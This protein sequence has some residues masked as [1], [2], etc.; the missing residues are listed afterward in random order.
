MMV[1]IGIG[2]I[3]LLAVII[4]ALVYRNK[5][6]AEQHHAA[7]QQQRAEATERINT[8][9]QQRDTALALLQ[10]SFKEESVYAT[11][12]THLALRCDFDNAW[13]GATGLHIAGIGADHAA[14][15]AVADSTGAAAD[16]VSRT[17]LSE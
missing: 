8:Q 12:P 5:A 4:V 11:D 3:M 7:M 16:H 10:E 15:A 14:S 1:F 13:S 17:D 2:L 9:R 6:A